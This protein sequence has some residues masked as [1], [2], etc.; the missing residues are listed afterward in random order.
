MGI[1]CWLVK[2]P[3]LGVLKLDVTSEWGHYE[4][5]ERLGLLSIPSLDLVLLTFFYYS[6]GCYTQ[7]DLEDT[8]KTIKSSNKC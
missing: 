8:I 2:T 1:A 7:K 4:G 5:T 3:Y 6:N